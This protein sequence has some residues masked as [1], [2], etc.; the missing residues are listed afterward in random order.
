VAPPVHP[1]K[2][3]IPQAVVINFMGKRFGG[4][5]L[6]TFTLTRER[7]IFEQIRGSQGSSVTSV[8][9][10]QVVKP[11]PLAP[12]DKVLI[13]GDTGPDWTEID[14]FGERLTYVTA[15][16]L[17]RVVTKGVKDLSHEVIAF[18]AY[19]AALPEDGIFV[20]FWT[21]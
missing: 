3:I 20:F 15:G 7:R 13:H 19:V 18:F 6:A 11:H 10:P 1:V 8:A 16:E 5:P 9:Y 2:R 21:H 17:R 14:E 4:Y 12:G